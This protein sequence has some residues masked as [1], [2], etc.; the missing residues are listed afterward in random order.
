MVNDSIGG[1]IGNPVGFLNSVF[2]Q[3]LT[4]FVVAIIILLVGFIL[5]RILGKF[6]QRFLGEIEFNK[7]VKRATG[8]D[9]SIEEWIGNFV[10]YFV[11]FITIVMALGHIGLTTTV[12]N[13]ISA[14]VIIIILISIVL[15]IKDFAPNVL[16]GLTIHNKKL[17]REGDRLKTKNAEGKVI[18][19]NLVETRIKTSRGDIIYIPN[20]TLIKSEFIK[21]SPKKK[22]K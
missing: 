6:S 9:V 15:A 22:R 16:A 1:A 3:V 20:A 17:I 7:M 5:A 18:Y 11:Y 4:K 8:K 12:L 2:S 10:M 21:V 19:I 14:A 13:M